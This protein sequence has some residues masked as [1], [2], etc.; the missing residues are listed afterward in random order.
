MIRRL[1]LSTAAAMLALWAVG[2]GAA[3]AM[4]I[5]VNAS[6]TAHCS[7]AGK[8]TLTPS[9]VIGGTAASVAFRL[10]GNLV[11]TG[12]SGVV[13]GK[14]AAS[15]T[16]STN[17]CTSEDSPPTLATVTVKWNAPGVKLNPSVITA[18]N[19]LATISADDVLIQVP[20][21]GPNPPAGTTSISGS[22]AGE[23]AVASLVT[24]QSG[25]DFITA[26][27]SKKGVKVMTFSG[28]HGPSTFDIG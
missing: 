14:L 18:S 1:A 20:S 4:K 17:D 3:Q 27:G 24:D 25:T 21:P 22:F 8:A 28:V 12:T 10:K 11:C 13:R 7:V 6:G 5:P 16:T 2:G 23:H 9:L 26:C 15:G 19:G